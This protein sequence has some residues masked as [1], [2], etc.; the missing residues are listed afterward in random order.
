MGPAP[1]EDGAP[2]LWATV[3]L[4]VQSCVSRA[5]VPKRSSQRNVKVLARVCVGWEEQ[6]RG[7][8]K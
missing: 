5:K 2:V 3:K 1:K 6:F 7:G 8:K 4:D